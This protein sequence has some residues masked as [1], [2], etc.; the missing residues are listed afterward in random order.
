MEIRLE[1]LIESARR[2]EGTV[3]IIDVYRAFTS[4]AVA[5][6]RGAERILLTATPEEALNLRRRGLGELCMGEVAGRKPE[7]FDLSNSPYELS[8]A[9]LAGRVLIQSTRAGTVGVCAAEGA[10]ALYAASLTVARATA[11]AIRRA[12]PPLV[13]IVAMGAEGRVRSD[14]DEQCALYIRNL[15]DGRRP[16]RTCVRCLVEVGAESQKYGDPARPWFHA[17]DREIALQIDAFDFPIRVS[18][19]DDL[20]VARRG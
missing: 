20:C 19:E 17:M 14:E 7:G 3:V 4:A 5:L 8:Q 2:A 11:E 12:A 13:T 1:S 10:S 6:S 9:D 16:D 15:L 18:R